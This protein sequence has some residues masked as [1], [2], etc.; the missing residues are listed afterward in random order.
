M[1][2]QVPLLGTIDQQGTK[3]GTNFKIPSLAT[4]RHLQKEYVMVMVVENVKTGVVTS[5][6]RR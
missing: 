3:A 5:Q 4:F 1:L 6:R 2:D